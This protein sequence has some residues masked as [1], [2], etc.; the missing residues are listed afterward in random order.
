MSNRNH[1]ADLIKGLAVLFMIQVHIMELFANETIYNSSFGK[2]SLFLGAVPV[3][4]VFTILLGY[5]IAVTNPTR[6]QLIKRGITTFCIGMILNIALNF[7]L[8]YSVYQGKFKLDI[9]PYVFGV[10]ILQFAGLSMIMMAILKP[11]FNKHVL[12]LIL[13]I[14]LSVWLSQY[15]LM[16][17]DLTTTLTYSTSFI[18]G[19]S[20]W[21]YFPLFPWLAYPLAGMLFFKLKENYVFKFL[22][23]PKIKLITALIGALFLLTTFKYANTITFNLTSYYHHNCIF[24]IWSIIFISFYSLWISQINS[25]FVNA[26]IS[27]Y[28]KWLG[29]HV[30]LVYCLQWILIGNIA[31]EIYKTIEDPIQL[32]WWFLGILTIVSG[33]AYLTIELKKRLNNYLNV[34]KK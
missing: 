29:Q 19:N 7:N 27:K 33:L 12:F 17:T 11:L 31:T 5:F 26:M 4:T 34:F 25:W 23:A 24:F 18:Y 2:L 15:L 14:M 10:D 20:H 16:F 6:W 3:A 1:T 30:T 22:N 32:L 9:Y 13:A 28:F 8:L 21:S